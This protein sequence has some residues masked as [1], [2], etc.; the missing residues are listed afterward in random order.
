MPLVNS[1]RPVAASRPPSE[2]TQ[3]SASTPPPASTKRRRQD[4][5]T[6]TDTPPSTG[7]G[8]IRNTRRDKDIPKKKKAARACFHCQKA[9]LTC[10]DC[11]YRLTLTLNLSSS[12]LITWLSARPCQRCTRRGMAGSCVEGHR[13]RAKYLLGEA[14]LG[15]SLFSRAS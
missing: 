8:P 12:Y 13:K 15:P 11:S 4:T 5:A 14:E 9:H 7:T 6:D 1:L 3:T 2:S 10:D